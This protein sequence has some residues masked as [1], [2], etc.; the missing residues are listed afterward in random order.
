MCCKGE[1]R[2]WRAVLQQAID[3][4]VHGSFDEQ[5][6]AFSW[7]FMPDKDFSAICD[8]ADVSPDYVRRKAW[9]RILKGN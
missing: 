4:L 9:N 7:L 3:D 6:R 5:R 1:L 2:M 8:Y